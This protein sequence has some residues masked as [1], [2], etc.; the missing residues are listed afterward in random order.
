MVSKALEKL[1]NELRLLSE[2][3]FRNVK[4]INCLE[5][6]RLGPGACSG[7]PPQA[8]S[9]LRHPF[10]H[11]R[12]RIRGG[13][14]PVAPRFRSPDVPEHLPD[15]LTFSLAPSGP[16]RRRANKRTR[17]SPRWQPRYWRAR[18]VPEPNE[19]ANHWMQPSRAFSKP[20]PDGAS[21]SCT[22]RLF[23]STPL[24]EKLDQLLGYRRNRL[25]RSSG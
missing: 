7:E 16:R 22:G 11:L 25:A 3:S 10:R 8:D 9:F 6:V 12:P 17:A 15:T 23:P 1:S 4:T 24:A 19:A 5:R 2:S 14:A 13:P 21:G 18:R 20:K